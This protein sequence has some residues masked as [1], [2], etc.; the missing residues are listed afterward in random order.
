VSSYEHA[1]HSVF[2]R[3]VKFLLLAFQC[4]DTWSEIY[5]SSAHGLVSVKHGREVA[6]SECCLHFIFTYTQVIFDGHTV[7]V[8][9]R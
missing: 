9:W 1:A 2:V 6:E 4:Y 5:S 3:L 7:G 8:K